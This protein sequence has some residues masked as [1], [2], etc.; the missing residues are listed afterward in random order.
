MEATDA[1]ILKVFWYIFMV[2]GICSKV[3]YIL[4]LAQCISQM[5][6]YE[7]KKGQSF[8]IHAKVFFPILQDLCTFFETIHAVSGRHWR[9]YGGMG[10]NLPLFV[11]MVLCSPI[12]KL[13][14]N[15]SATLYFLATFSLLS[16]FQCIEQL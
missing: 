9:S 16:N 8:Y 2:P 13:L 7:I 4:H 10:A 6:G 15:L 12:H 14:G 3:S 1:E 11:T 5:L